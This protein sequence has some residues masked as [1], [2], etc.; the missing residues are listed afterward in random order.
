MMLNSIMSRFG[1]VIIWFILVMLRALYAL[2]VPKKN[3]AGTKKSEVLIL[4]P[5][6]YIH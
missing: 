4:L 6:I 2:I 3:T 5:A 1:T